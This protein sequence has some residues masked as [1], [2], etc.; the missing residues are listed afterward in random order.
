MSIYCYL[1]CR[2]C[3]ESLFVK[4]ADS[5]VHANPEALGQF[6]EKHHMH[7]LLFGDELAYVTSD[8]LEG[9]FLE[10]WDEFEMS[11]DGCWSRGT[12]YPND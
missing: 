9:D 3:R 12:F 6:L 7:P 11:Q 8:K 1:A 2:D 4:D 10:D 5:V